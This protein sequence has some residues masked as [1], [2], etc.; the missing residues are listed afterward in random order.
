MRPAIKL[1]MP[2]RA[3]TNKFGLKKEDFETIEEYRKAYN[4][5]S[6]KEHQR[7]TYIKKGPKKNQFGLNRDDFETIEDYRKAYRKLYTKTEAYKLSERK[8]KAKYKKTEKGKAVY[9]KYEE[10]EKGKVSRRA[11]HLRHKETELYKLSR[12]RAKSSEKGKISNARYDKSE[13]GRAAHRKWEQSE[14]GRKTALALRQKRRARKMN[15][16]PAWADLKKIKEF[17]IKCP[18][19]MHVD[20]IAPLG[21]KK[22]CGLHVIENLQ[23]LT[24][25]ENHSKNN[26]ISKEELRKLEIAQTEDANNFLNKK[27][28]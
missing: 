19:G 25:E 6:A 10:S 20:H 16:T 28:C 15:A 7:R 14:I 24:P 23:Y 8:S 27:R 1:L 2:P 13:K 3:N 11:R 9:R 4:N 22:M 21:S 18:E 26:K 5:L 12:A 17:I